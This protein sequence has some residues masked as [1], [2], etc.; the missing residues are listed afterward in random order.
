VAQFLAAGFLTA[1]LIAA[2]TWVLSGRA[3]NTEAT[4][5]ARATT[6]I[7]AHSVAEPTIPRG[8]A[9]GD[10]GA[11][12]RFDRQVDRLLVPD[13]LR[14]KIWG[15]DGTIVYSDKNA[16]IGT[17]YDL[18]DE[19]RDILAHGGIEAEVSDLDRPENRFE[20]SSS[21]VVEVYTS[22][23]SPEGLPLL[24]EA[25]FS[26]A[27]LDARKQQVFQPFYRIT[28]GGL[29]ILLGVATPMLWVLTRRLTRAA[30]DRERLLRTA[31]TASDNERRR[32][33]RDLHDGVVQ[34]LAGTAFAVGALARSETDPTHR[35]A[36]ERT[37]ASLRGTLRSL[38]SLLVEI[39]PPDLQ[40]DGLAAALADLTAPASAAGTRATV[41]VSGMG[42][43]GDAQV[44]LV[45][46]VAQE[47]VRNAIRHAE[48]SRISVVVRG[49]GDR[50]VLEVSDDGKG[51]RPDTPAHPNSFGLRGL[52]S[53]VA[54]SG[55]RLEV[56][57]LPGH[58]TTIRLE[59]DR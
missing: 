37:G 39:H 49:T 42:G 30:N 38:R 7:L 55:G 56:R 2:G 46:R 59:V 51:F 25:Y 29:A 32:I 45:W 27:D 9:T 16:L 34:D 50:V 33:A 44:A 18:G 23:E 20:R 10:P 22:I 58:G 53:L 57:S 41:E 6:E 40:A 19:E 21:G 28:L 14:I 26:A 35:E 24:F 8:L 5:D 12:D 13:V 31:A 47:A 15:A 48:A 3:A 17:S 11:I 52:Q 43:V 54:D 4:T 1:L 36:L